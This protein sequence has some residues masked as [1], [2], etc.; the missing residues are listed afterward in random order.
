MSDMS[1]HAQPQP[2][3]A[4]DQ[5]DPLLVA[6]VAAGDEPDPARAQE[7]RRWLRECPDCA[8]LAADLQRVSAAVA[9]EP[10]P[11]RG[12]DFRLTPEQ[13]EQLDG[14]AFSRFL[15]RLSWPRSRA[16]GPAAAGIMSLGLAFVVVGY[17]LPEDGAISVQSE[18]NVPAASIEAPAA[19]TTP[20][21][22]VAP[23]VGG[24]ERAAPAAPDAPAAEEP[25]LEEAIEAFAA[26][27]DL[28]EGLEDHQA[29]MSARSKAAENT[30]E[31]ELA[32]DLAADGVASEEA[33]ADIVGQSA[34]SLGEPA[35]E[36][37]GDATQAFDDLAA[38]SE[39][40]DGTGV[41]Q[42]SDDTLAAVDGAEVLA[43]VDDDGPVRWLILV[44]VALA[45][46]G[47]ALLLLAWLARRDRD[48][49]LR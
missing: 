12:R 44:G 26:D 3:H 36:P 30:A 17:A 6:Q 27:P 34:D 46:S 16:F 8:A 35:A 25:R 29:G 28:L 48:P 37:D 2:A 39:Q 23:S 40:S 7:A 43:S 14:S 24:G 41:D 4:H 9:S 42:V 20:A 22:D 32:D 38:V 33:V 45:I 31:S 47:G 1:R 19:A 13:A 11:T 10:V 15:R 5:H 21:L 49:L 18:A